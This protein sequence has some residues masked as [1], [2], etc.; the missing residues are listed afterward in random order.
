MAAVTLK[1]SEF[2][3][4]V[5]AVCSL[6]LE[7]ITRN[8][9]RYMR[10]LLRETQNIWDFDFTYDD[11]TVAEFGL[12]LNLLSW[13]RRFGNPIP[14]PNLANTFQFMERF[15]LHAD[16]WIGTRTGYNTNY[17]PLSTFECSKLPQNYIDMMNE[18]IHTKAEEAL[19]S[20]MER[21]MRKWIID[22][23]PTSVSERRFRQSRTKP[24][25]LSKLYIF[26]RKQALR[27]ISF[28]EIFIRDAA[29]SIF[30]AL[31]KERD[32]ATN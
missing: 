6:E 11:T 8:I 29:Q 20:E 26:V 17:K 16:T 19:Y 7:F 2:R 25:K 1:F 15:W 13:R 27:K 5:L 21:N 30:D 32:R 9:E 12:K 31:V 3:K 14:A 4:S 23:K 24:I 28:S 22:G 18:K 10:E